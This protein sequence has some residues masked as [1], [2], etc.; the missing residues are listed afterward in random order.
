MR[1][2]HG[3]LKDIGTRGQ[4]QGQDRRVILEEVH[5]HRD[6]DLYSSRS[7]GGEFKRLR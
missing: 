6:Q 7:G 3:R 2:L 5:L 4:P 1:R